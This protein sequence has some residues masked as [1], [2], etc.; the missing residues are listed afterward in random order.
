MLLKNCLGGPKLH[1]VLW[2]SPC[3]D[4]TQLSHVN[5]LL[6]YAVTKICN[7]TLTDYKWTQASLPLGA[8][9]LGV[10]TSQSLHRRHFLASATGTQTLHAP[11]L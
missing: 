2:T 11:I 10:Q 1:Q 5:H 4:H 7:V 3:C 9:D 8:G 6:R